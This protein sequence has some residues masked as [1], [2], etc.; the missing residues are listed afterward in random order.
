[1]G[2]ADMRSKQALTHG[3][4]P[5]RPPTISCPLCC[6]VGRGSQLEVGFML[7][8]MGSGGLPVHMPQQWQSQGCGFQEHL[9]GVVS[10]MFIYFGLETTGPVGCTAGSLGCTQSIFTCVHKLAA[11]G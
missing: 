2:L 9:I 8:L 10:V 4:L 5:H 11:T 6:F 3:T 7:S 1:M